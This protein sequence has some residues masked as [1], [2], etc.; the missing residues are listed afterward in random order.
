MTEDT[1]NYFIELSNKILRELQDECIR[2]IDGSRLDKEHSLRILEV[3]SKCELWL[4]VLLTQTEEIGGFGS[5]YPKKCLDSLK[6][7]RT[8]LDMEI[9]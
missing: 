8:I 2:D 6:L 9:K 7:F 5:S 3:I 1:K 4:D